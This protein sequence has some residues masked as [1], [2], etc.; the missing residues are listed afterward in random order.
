M[1][2]YAAGIP[3]ELRIIFLPAP[4]G[5]AKMKHLEPAVQWRAFFADPATGKEHAIG[6]V[7]ADANGD[8]QMPDSPVIQD[9]ICVLERV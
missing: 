9:W 6:T 3:G 1:R 8:W 4:G 2:P 7:K 5:G